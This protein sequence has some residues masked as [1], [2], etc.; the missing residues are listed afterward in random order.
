MDFFRLEKG[1]VNRPDCL[2]DCDLDDQPMTK[3]KAYFDISLATAQTKDRYIPTPIVL[4]SC[5]RL[6]RRT[7]LVGMGTV[8]LVRLARRYP[9]VRVE[10]GRGTQ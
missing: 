6:A 9:Y 10:P 3:L 4:A 1:R 7:R 2:D 5:G 8:A